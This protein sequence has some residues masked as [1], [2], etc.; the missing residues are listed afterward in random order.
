MANGDEA[1]KSQFIVI[2]LIPKAIKHKFIKT[3]IFIFNA[4]LSYQKIKKKQGNYDRIFKLLYNKK[5]D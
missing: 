2:C 1:L 4:Y 5:F 3:Q